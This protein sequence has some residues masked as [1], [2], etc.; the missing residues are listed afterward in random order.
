MRTG[1]DALGSYQEIAAGY[2]G[3]RRTAVFRLY[4]NKPA[5]CCSIGIAERTRMLHPS[6]LFTWRSK[7]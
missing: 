1:A 2:G 6:R 7:G 4:L 5:G 3:S